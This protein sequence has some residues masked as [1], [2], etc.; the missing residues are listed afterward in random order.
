MKFVVS[1]Q[2]IASVHNKQLSPREHLGNQVCVCDI[3]RDIDKCVHFIFDIDS[4][5]MCEKA[6]TDKCYVRSTI[7]CKGAQEYIV[8]PFTSTVRV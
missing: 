8:L 5:R 7:S 6:R 3:Y 2:C 1:N 4:T